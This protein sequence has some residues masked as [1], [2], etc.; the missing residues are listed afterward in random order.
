MLKNK[1]GQMN[2]IAFVFG[3]LTFFLIWGIWLGKFIAE[4]C[5]NA[6]IENGYT[7]IEAFGLEYMNLWI[8]LMILIVIAFVYYL[9]GGN[10]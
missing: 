7:G 6:V 4:W 5:H 3:L 9:S 1:R 10:Q 8:F 2:I